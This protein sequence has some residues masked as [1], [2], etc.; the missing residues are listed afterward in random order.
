MASEEQVSLD[1]VR[2]LFMGGNDIN[3]FAAM[4]DQTAIAVYKAHDNEGK[5][6]PCISLM[7]QWTGEGGALSLDKALELFGIDPDATIWKL[8]D[9]NDGTRA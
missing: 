9:P 1:Q 6:R 4:K 5:V 8:G 2:Q 3:V 7:L